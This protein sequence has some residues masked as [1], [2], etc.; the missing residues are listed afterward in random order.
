MNMVLGKGYFERKKTAFRGGYD[1]AY[2]LFLFVL[3]GTDN[4]V[5][6]VGLEPTQP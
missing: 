4:M 5:P 6:G 2:C 3:I 1:I